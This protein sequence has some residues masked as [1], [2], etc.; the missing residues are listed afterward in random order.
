MPKNEIEVVVDGGKRM[1]QR[2]FWSREYSG[3]VETKESALQTMWEYLGNDISKQTKNWANKRKG[4]EGHVRK[5]VGLV[6]KTKEFRK[7]SMWM[8]TRK[9]IRF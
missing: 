4:K 7:A 3:H 9:S 2:S 8:G 1:R 6:K 5:E